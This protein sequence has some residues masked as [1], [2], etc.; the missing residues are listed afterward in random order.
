MT[1][2]SPTHTHNALRTNAYTNTTPTP[3]HTY[4]HTHTHTHPYIHTPHEHIYTNSDPALCRNCCVVLW[5]FS[6]NLKTH[7]GLAAVTVM[8]VLFR[9]T[10]GTTYVQL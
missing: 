1:S 2:L 4:T 8:D 10:K 5:I 6:S 9:T 3:T 7:A